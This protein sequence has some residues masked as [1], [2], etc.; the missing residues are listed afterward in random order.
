M[1]GKLVQILNPTLRTAVFLS[2]MAVTCSQQT[3]F[4]QVV[5]LG[6]SEAGP[7]VVPA[8]PSDIGY[9]VVAPDRG[10][11][12]NEEVRDA[13]MEFSQLF[14]AEVAFLPWRGDVAKYVREALSRLHDRGALRMVVLPLVVADAHP[15]LRRL[16]Q[17]LKGGYA[18][19]RI[20]DAFGQSYLAEEILIDRLRASALLGPTGHGV[21]RDGDSEDGKPA[22]VVVSGGGLGEED[23]IRWIA[24]ELQELVRPAVNYFDVSE[25]RTVVLRHV[26]AG[27]DGVQ[28]S[29]EHFKR[30]VDQLVESH[31]QVVV[32]PFYLGQRMDSMMDEVQFLRR[33]VDGK[34]AE[35]LPPGPLPHEL[36]TLWMCQEANR[37]TPLRNDEV[38]FVV[39]PH[40]SD[41]DWN[42]SIRQPLAELGQHYP[43][44][45]AFSMADSE[46]LRRAVRR[47]EARGYRGIVVLRVF[48]LESSFRD[49][50]DFLL[51]LSETSGNSMGMGMPRRVRSAAIFETLGGVE[52]HP[53][54]ARALL[55]RAREISTRPTEEALFLLGHGSGP[56]PSNQ[57]WLDNLASLRQQISD[58]G[59]AFASGHVANWQEDWPALRATAAA[60]IRAL[61]NV[62]IEQGRTVLV[63]PARITKTGPEIEELAH[64]AR[65]RVG[66]GFA[67]HPLF[68]TWVTS[69]F[70]EGRRRLIEVVNTSAGR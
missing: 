60:E 67:P 24:E 35:V 65:V 48:S 39:M 15:L 20:A 58:L 28:A 17:S 68:R 34:A 25:A 62:E 12:G 57:A 69:Q 40:G 55:D 70:E 3:M 11:L 31:G 64:L 44:E 41:I 18:N 43:L 26:T 23:E 61:V 7:L 51:G 66:T 45:Y 13:F 27:A 53:L 19:V 50:I 46:V 42:E 32:V 4:S 21:G 8:E 14:R 47:L 10:F 63:V 56:G 16:E 6:V 5:P 2:V 52:D 37:W 9:V 38:G 59:H 33:Q 30:E 54:F 29:F 36:V 49:R 22:V 1:I